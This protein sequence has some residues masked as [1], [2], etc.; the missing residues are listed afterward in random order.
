MGFKSLVINKL[1]L[2]IPCFFPDLC[3]QKL[4]NDL[5]VRTL[6]LV[7]GFELTYLKW[8][9][10]TKGQQNTT[11]CSIMNAKLCQLMFWPSHE[12]GSHQDDSKNVTH[13]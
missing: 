12:N 10:D 8:K 7:I 1:F 5:D 3:H 13:V 4:Q 9:V 6:P 2:S 11:L